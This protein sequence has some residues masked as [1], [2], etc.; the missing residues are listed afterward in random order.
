M[1]DRLDGPA[2]EWKQQGDG[3]HPTLAGN[4]LDP[5]VQADG[6]MRAGQGVGGT[7]EGRIREEGLEHIKKNTDGDYSGSG[8]SSERP[9]ALM[10]DTQT[11][12][13]GASGL[14][15][16]NDYARGSDINTGSG[17][18][19]T[20]SY[21]SSATG[22]QKQGGMLDTV[23]SYLGMGG[24]QQQEARNV[25][26]YDTTSGSGLSRAEETGLGAGAA[27][28]GYEGERALG[29]DS[30]YDQSN[31]RGSLAGDYNNE[32]NLSGQGTSATI[33]NDPMK[34]SDAST[35]R[36]PQDSDVTTG[37]DPTESADPSTAETAM[38]RGEE[39]AERSEGGESG[40][41]TTKSS[42]DKHPGS[43]ENPDAIPTAGGEKLGKKHWGESKIVPD[44]PK[45][46]SESGISSSE[47]QPNQQTADNTSANTGGA[48]PPGQNDNYTGEEKQG[49]A[50]K[51]KGTL[52][53]G[54]NK[55]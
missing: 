16:G 36:N 47:G 46:Q 11:N 34:E 5:G 38:P 41:S 2:S 30:T 35:S 24:A 13:S 18:T 23:K 32:Q 33:S 3:P 25:D 27:S 28:A 37:R 44:N 4:V 7:S 22:E 8:I 12:I 21:D 9:N 55:H 10:G 49:L 53:L 43:R 45:P 51:V 31:Q 15:G 40:E 6:Q 20:S 1:T 19:G 42:G 52:H 14:T 50:A 29:G 48:A 39:R 17:L 26:S 54:G